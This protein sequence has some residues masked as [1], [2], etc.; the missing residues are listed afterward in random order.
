VVRLVL[1][2]VDEER[3]QV[4]KV[5]QGRERRGV[6]HAR[7]GLDV[8]DVDVRKRHF[9]CVHAVPRAHFAGDE[10]PGVAARAAHHLQR[11]RAFDAAGHG[12]AAARGAAEARPHIAVRAAL[13]ADLA[14]PLVGA[15][16]A[17][18]AQAT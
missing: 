6:G 17:P 7:E 14:P 3:L 4:R 1:V 15:N 11:S 9:F 18:L 2:V 12:E 10:G 13:D 16:S 5:A 8:V